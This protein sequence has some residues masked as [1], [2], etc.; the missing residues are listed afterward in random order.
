LLSHDVWIRRT[1]HGEFFPF[2]RVGYLGR[3]GTV[4]PA[5]R[6][7]AGID[8]LHRDRSRRGADQ[9]TEVAAYAFGFHNVWVPFAV[10]LLPVK[11]LV[12][13]VFTGYIAKIAADAVFD[14]YV[15]FYVIVQV[16]ITPISDV[17]DRLADY[18]VYARKALLVEIVVHP[19]DHVLNDAVTVM[20]DRRANLDRSGAEQHEFDRIPPGVDAADAGYRNI[21]FLIASQFR[22][23]VKG[24]RLNCS[25]AVSAMRRHAVDVRVRNERI[26]VN[27]HY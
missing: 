22:D 18:I 21:K 13:S 7:A 20:H 3:S 26:D 27:A 10:D 8:S 19:V 25:A 1:R 23:H 16:E 24:D 9:I 17:V 12:R 14:V 2:L 11:A 15:S 5:L 6:G 4:S